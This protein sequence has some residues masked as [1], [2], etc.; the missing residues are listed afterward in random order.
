M[1]IIRTCLSQA[2]VVSVWSFSSRSRVISLIPNLSTTSDEEFIRG[3][4]T[5]VPSFSYRLSRSRT[6]RVSFDK[7]QIN[8]LYEWIFKDI[9]QTQ[10][11]VEHNTTYTYNYTLWMIR[12]HKIKYAKFRAGYIECIIFFY[13]AD[14]VLHIELK[15]VFSGAWFSVCLI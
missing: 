6:R 15:W 4:L 8:E 13:N 12:R 7:L 14:G 3:R 5:V 10:R 1:T 9:F 2:L 11:F